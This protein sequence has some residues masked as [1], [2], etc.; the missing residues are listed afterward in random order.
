MNK[1]CKTCVMDNS[2][3]AIFTEDGM[4]NFC[5]NY[6]ILESLY[7]NNLESLTKV[8]KTFE[9]IKISSS[10]KNY[11]CVVGISGGTDSCYTLKFLVE[12]GLRPLAV[13][14]DNGWNTEVSVS[15]I[16][17]VVKKLDVDLYTYVVDWEEFKDIQKAFLYSSTPDIDQPTDQGIRGALFKVAQQEGLK[18]VIVGNNFRNEGKVP[19]HWSYS[20]GYY[21]KN[22]H[23]EFGIKK[24]ITYPLITPIELIKYKALGIKIIKPLWYVKY[25]KSEIKPILEREFGWKDYG[26]HH[27]ENVYTRFAHAYYLVKKFGFDKRKVELSAMILSKQISRDN[28]LDMLKVIPYSNIIIEEDIAYVKKKLSISDIEFEKIMNCKPK[29]FSDYKSLYPILKRYQNFWRLLSKNILDE[30]PLIFQYM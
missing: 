21:V 14:F 18:H 2:T 26:G 15:N 7:P 4:C 19:I 27:Y 22:I 8:R 10:S 16:K 1:I 20:D 6:R 3:G 30:T 28:A 5:N 29:L 9:Q 13:H 11:D 12:N 25:I 24:I 23:Q 17:K